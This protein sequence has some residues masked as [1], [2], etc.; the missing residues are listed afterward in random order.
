MSE[1][2][3]GLLMQIRTEPLADPAA[4][5]D[6]DKQPARVR[7]RPRPPVSDLWGITP[8]ACH[9]DESTPIIRERRKALG[10]VDGRAGNAANVSECD[11][12]ALSAAT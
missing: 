6:R 10:Q 9:Y 8:R 7:D 2:I 12:Y 3:Q 4:R 5:V 11:S 1:Q